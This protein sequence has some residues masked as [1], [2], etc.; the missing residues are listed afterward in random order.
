MVIINEK[1]WNMREQFQ[2]AQYNYS[3]KKRNDRSI[4]LLVG[5]E[6]NIF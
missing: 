3:I 2:K 1:T 6:D 5:V 4:P